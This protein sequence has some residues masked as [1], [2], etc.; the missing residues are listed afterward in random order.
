VS[1]SIL[2]FSLLA[3][4][5]IFFIV[6]PLGA[7]P[8]FLAVT[9]GQSSA[10][11]RKTALK[12]ALVA[13]GVL[14]T[15]ALAGQLIFKLFGITMGAFRVAGGILLLRVALDMLHGHASRTKST[16]EDHLAA[17]EKDDVA[18]TPL[19]VPQL[20]GPGAIA[21]VTMLMSEKLPLWRVAPVLASVLLVGLITY[22]VLLGAAPL[23]RLLGETGG[24]ILTKLMGLLLAAVAVQFM[25]Q[26]VRELLPLILAKGR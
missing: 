18:I 15:F 25:A 11:R 3:F 4:T 17:A 14:I 19:G 22:F 7:A 21:T 13:T 8:V 5:S 24:R 23:Q 10:E 16:E 20:A 1:S 9:A 12:S 2:S 6:N 26:G